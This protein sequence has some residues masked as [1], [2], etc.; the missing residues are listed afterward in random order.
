[1]V[2]VS[3]PNLK[4]Y[5]RKDSTITVFFNISVCSQTFYPN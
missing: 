4:E 5:P 1:V 3:L 2:A